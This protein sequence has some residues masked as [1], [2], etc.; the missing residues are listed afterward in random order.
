MRQF[1]LLAFII[2]CFTGVVQANPLRDQQLAARHINNF[3]FTGYTVGS[4]N[5]L[6]QSNKFYSGI[7]NRIYDLEPNGFTLQQINAT[8]FKKPKEGLGGLLSLV[9]GRDANQIALKGFNSNIFGIQNFGFTVAQAYLY[10]HYQS[11]VL[12]IG[13]MLSLAGIEVYDYTQVS[14]F[15]R[16]IISD[17]AQPGT[18]LGVRYIHRLNPYL[19][20]IAGAGNGWN[21]IEKPLQLDNIEL[22]LSIKFGDKFSFML[23]GYN[24]AQGLTDDSTTKPI[25]RRNF[26]DLYGTY[27][28]NQKL[29]LAFNY[30]YGY[31]PK[32]ALPSDQ[33][34]VAK[35]QGLAGYI[36]YEW[37]ERWKTSLR[38]EIFDDVNGY[39]TGIRQNWREVTLTI[40]YIPV[41]KFEVT[42]ETRHDFF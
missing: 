19:A 18:Y 15:S 27:Y 29:N 1:L 12:K 17:Y 20:I 21:T 37:A 42:A 2:L 35:W 9:A 40:T 25:T 28:I 34:G 41:K 14:N 6:T 31:Q 23:D 32:V 16:S 3:H 36:N 26:I 8:F 24:V 5:Y 39:R 10:Y 4:Y 13:E 11:N 30:D 22:G 7:Y 38:A 33:I